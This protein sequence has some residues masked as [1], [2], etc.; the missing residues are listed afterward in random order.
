MCVCALYSYLIEYDVC[1]LT[2]CE[3]TYPKKLAFS[4]LEELQKEFQEKHG[5]EVQ[6]AARPYALIKF[7]R[8]A[9]NTWMQYYLP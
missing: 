2:L 8:E 1:Y 3:K 4:Y 6:T 5:A 9:N 7:G